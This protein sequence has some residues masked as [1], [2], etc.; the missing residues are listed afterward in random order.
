MLTPQELA[1]WAFDKSLE[2]GQFSLPEERLFVMLDL[3]RRFHYHILSP[4]IEC[5]LR[6]KAGLSIDA[7]I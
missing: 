5:A 7:E 3:V 1:A 6:H 4:D 2:S